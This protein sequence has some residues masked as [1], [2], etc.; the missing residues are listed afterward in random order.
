MADT[1]TRNILSVCA[2]TSS[3][4]SNLP[5]KN[6]QMIF[7]HDKG[8]IA[9]DYQD[10]RKFYTQILELATDEERI[11]LE[12]PITGSYY[13]VVDTAILWAYQDGWIQLTNTPQE[14]L[15]IGVELPEL[16]SANK[17][18]INKK[19]RN[20]SIWDLETKSYLVISNYTEEITAEDID[21]L[22]EDDVI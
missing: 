16:G 8:W 20:I 12:D 4:L 17:L 6:G 2:T 19:Q 11:T 15:F 18:Y 10:K 1:T 9:F 7:V 22:F 21:D 3:K 13:F 14:I 5:I